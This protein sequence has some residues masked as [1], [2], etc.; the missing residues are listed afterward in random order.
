[1]TEGVEQEFMDEKVDPC[2]DFYRYACGGWIDRTEIQSE[3]ATFSRMEELENHDEHLPP[4]PA[5]GSV[6]GTAHEA[7][8]FLR[9]MHRRVAAGGS[10]HQLA[11]VLKMISPIRDRR[12]LASSKGHPSADHHAARTGLLALQ[13]GRA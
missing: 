10:R 7:W 6:P 5:G 3:R 8:R 1:M 13:R 12:S 9:G 11:G 2:D 4:D